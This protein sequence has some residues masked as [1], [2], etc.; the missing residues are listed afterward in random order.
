M[1]DRPEDSDEGRPGGHPIGQPA[2]GRRGRPGPAEEGE[3]PQISSV[4]RLQVGA[5]K[6][7]FLR[8]NPHPAA[9]TRPSPPPPPLHQ[10]RGGLCDQPVQ[11]GGGAGPRPGAEVQHVAG[12]PGTSAAAQRVGGTLPAGETGTK[13][14]FMSSVSQ[15]QY[16][17]HL[18]GSGEVK[19]SEEINSIL[20]K[21]SRAEAQL[22][23]SPNASRCSSGSI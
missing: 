2:E 10:R 4:G 6:H 20:Q 15:F 16:K 17:Q 23:K 9:L 1:H 8:L 18:H 14:L 22:V 13:S 19:S 21:V 7:A 5:N 12:T 11:P 3:R